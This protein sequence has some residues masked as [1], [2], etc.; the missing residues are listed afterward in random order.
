MRK[1]KKI[2]CYKIVIISLCIAIAANLA[3]AAYF[4]LAR[5]T[6][7][8][9][10]VKWVDFN[11]TEPAMSKALKIDIESRQTETPICWV[12]LLAYLGTKYGGNFKQ[13]K[14]SH[15]D[16]FAQKLRSGN[17]IETLTADMEYFNYYRDAYGLVLDGLVGEY[18]IQTAESLDSEE[19]ILQSKY[20]LKAYS[21]IAYGYSFSHYDDFGNSRSYG[22]RR[23]H[24]GNDLLG[25][26]GTPI[27]A[28]ESGVVETAGWNQY[29]GWRVGIRSFNG[30]R[31]YYYAHLRKDRPYHADLK[32]GSVIQAGDIIGY[33]GMTGYSNKENVN[34]MKT[35]HLHFGIELVP[36]GLEKERK[37]EIWINAYEIVKFLEHHKSPVLKNDE[38]KE[39]Y[40]KYQFTDPSV[41]ELNGMIPVFPK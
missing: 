35:P 24:L 29:G 19:P 37:S 13:Y 20:G 5:P 41:E 15:M 25:N 8:N 40:R 1:Y 28:V 6:M 26:I 27:I 23:Q 21:P 10:A 9:K 17:S 14:P 32:E 11:V 34:G 33:L 16:D 38:T 18:Q 39:Y 4:A 2:T 12:D 3:C 31:Y 7:A 36:D 30:Q 22:Y